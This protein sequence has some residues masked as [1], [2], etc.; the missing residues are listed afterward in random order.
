MASLAWPCTPSQYHHA[1]NLQIRSSKSERQPSALSIQRAATA[2]RGCHG[3]ACVAMHAVATSRR[4]GFPNPKRSARRVSQLCCTRKPSASSLIH[5]LQLSNKCQTSA[6]EAR[7]HSAPSTLPVTYL[8]FARKTVT[9]RV[10]PRGK[11]R[12]CREKKFWS[13]RGDFARS[14]AEVRAQNGRL[15]HLPPGRTP[16]CRD[17]QLPN[18][19]GPVPWLAAK[20]QPRGFT[21]RGCGRAAIHGTQQT[22]SS[23]LATP[24][25]D[26]PEFAE[27]R[28]RTR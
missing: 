5:H 1:L 12:P 2:S 25:A 6:K 9:W 20:R 16:P 8:V 22:G 7:A 3:L 14:P 17:C 15:A 27:K 28:N 18:T 11:S 13:F 19:E 10:S 23:L 24:P 26:L 4:P 21:I